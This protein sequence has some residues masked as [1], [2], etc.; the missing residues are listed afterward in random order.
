MAEQLKRWIELLSKSGSNTKKQV[1][2]EMKEFLKKV[3]D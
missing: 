3:G 2:E 1:L